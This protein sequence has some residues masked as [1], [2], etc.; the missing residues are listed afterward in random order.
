[1]KFVELSV[2]DLFSFAAREGV[3]CVKEQLRHATCCTP[4]TNYRFQNAQQETEKGFLDNNV[5]VTKII[6]PTE[7]KVVEAVAPV[8]PPRSKPKKDITKNPLS[9]GSPAKKEKK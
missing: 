9:F 4:K 5:T 3:I 1:M 7:N 8:S 2:G 6:P